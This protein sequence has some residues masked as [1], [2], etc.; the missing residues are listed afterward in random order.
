MTMDIESQRRIT[1]TEKQTI[2]ALR[3]I[4]AA[5]GPQVVLGHVANIVESVDAD[6]PEH[7]EVDRII[8]NLIH[9]SAEAIDTIIAKTYGD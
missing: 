3:K 4:L 9:A 1:V 8:A 7:R 6:V 2:A 5:T